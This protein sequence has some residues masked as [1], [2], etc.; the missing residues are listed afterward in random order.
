MDHQIRIIVCEDSLATRICLVDG[1]E[2][3]GL[4]TRGVSDGQSLDRLLTEGWGEI[5]ILDINL[6]GEDGFSIAERVR[7]HYPD[8]GIVMLTARDP[9]EDRIRGLEEGA[10]L[11]FVKP[12]DL[13]ELAAALRSLHRRLV[14]GRDATWRLH[15]DYSRLDT[16]SGLGI[17]LTDGELRVLVPLVE[18]AGEVVSRDEILAALG[19]AP[20]YYA[21]RRLETL[22][23]RLRKKVLA[24][25]S[26]EPLPVRAR[27]GE[28]Y[29][30]AAD[31]GLGATVAG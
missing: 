17:P 31:G 9:L 10:D 24:T 28:G 15:A 30:F 8:L 27:H 7:R 3:L 22:L 5:L 2:A 14:P 12:V 11:Y 20:D 25:S 21:T 1:L 6:P 4:A 18:R 26:D 29:I 16:P 13:R 19:Q 23:S